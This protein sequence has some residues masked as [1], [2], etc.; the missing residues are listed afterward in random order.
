[1][2]ADKKQRLADIERSIDT[3][4]SVDDYARIKEKLAELDSN[5]ELRDEIAN[6][7][8]RCD[9]AIMVHVSK[10]KNEKHSDRKSFKKKLAIVVSGC[11]VALAIIAL[12]LTVLMPT[13]HFNRGVELMDNGDYRGAIEEL[14]Q[15]SANSDSRSLIDACTVNLVDDLAVNDSVFLGCWDNNPIEWLVLKVEDDRS[16]L[17]SK[18][19]LSKQ[20]YD[21]SGG[22]IDPETDAYD[23]NLWKNCSLRTWLNNDFYNTAF[24]DQSRSVIVRSTNSQE[25]LDADKHGGPDTNDN[26]FILDYTQAHNYYKN[27]SQVKDAFGRDPFW[28]RNP[29]GTNGCFAKVW[30]P[31]ESSSDYESVSSKSGVRPAIWVSSKAETLSVRGEPPISVAD[32]AADNSGESASAHSASSTSPNQRNSSTSNGYSS[33]QKCLSCNGTGYVKYYAGE[34]GSDYTYGTCTQCNGTG[35]VSR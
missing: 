10:L 15:S 4:A 9:K 25:K 3:A 12:I 19:I 11:I 26:V 2:A 29:S 17:V 27:S 22:G 5:K 35:Y 34:D 31:Y 8:K 1:M 30:V 7:R 14:I 13:L 32:T 33:K 24:G 6:L 16:L 23:A 21:T 18:E 28:L 20:P